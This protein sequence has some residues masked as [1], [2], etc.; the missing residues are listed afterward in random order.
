MRTVILCC[1][2]LCQSAMAKQA[3]VELRRPGPDDFKMTLPLQIQGEAAA[4]RLLLPDV[5]Y[6]TVDQAEL[7]HLA[8]FNGRGEPVPWVLE[9]PSSEPTSTLQTL[10]LVLFDGSQAASRQALGEG[11]KHLSV[12]YNEDNLK[13]DIDLNPVMSNGLQQAGPQPNVFY[14]DLGKIQSGETLQQLT[15]KWSREVGLHFLID[16]EVDT[17]TDFLNWKRIGKGRLFQ[18]MS[19]REY[20]EHHLVRVDPPGG[21]YLRIRMLSDDD[22]PELHGVMGNFKTERMSEVQELWFDA[23]LSPIGET[24]EFQFELPARHS[25]QRLRVTTEH[26]NSLGMVTV[27]YWRDGWVQVARAAL[28]QLTHGNQSRNKTELRLNSP[29]AQRWKLV[30]SSESLGY[31]SP[32]PQVMYSLAPKELAFVRYGDGP[33]SLAV[34]VAPDLRDVLD[35]SSSRRHPE[36]PAR[37]QQSAAVIVLPPHYN[38][39]TERWQISEGTAAPSRAWLFWVGAILF[40]VVM[41]LLAL[42][43][44]RDINQTYRQRKSTRAED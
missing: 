33:Y 44:Y 7:N 31:T 43:L 4:Y 3:P 39:A 23:A 30:F 10:P 38:P 26:Q 22:I 16:V 41:L 18:F 28:A 8:V 11:R 34:G 17:S 37:A 40:V 42:Y 13:V 15:F 1:L 27:F 35:W 6:E 14:V 19:G 24:D 20:M 32:S 5:V 9:N 12:Y 21:R 36:F 29:P 25:I 2:L